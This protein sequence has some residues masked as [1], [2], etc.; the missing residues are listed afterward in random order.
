MLNIILEFLKDPVKV[1]QLT[2]LIIFLTL[3]GVIIISA[4]LVVSLKNIF[5]CALFLALSF[6]GVAGIYILLNAEFIAA[7]Q[8]LIYVG[9]ITVLIIFA[10]MLSQKISGRTLSQTNE[11]RGAAILVSLSMLAFLSIVLTRT[12][13]PLSREGSLSHSTYA[14]GKLLLTTYVLPFE[15]ASVVLLVAMIGAIIFVRR[16]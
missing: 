1:G 6:L 15:V 10:V 8:V 7:V 13:F 16:E 2:N 5:H 4:L 9:A 3:S 11:Q 14:L 12:V